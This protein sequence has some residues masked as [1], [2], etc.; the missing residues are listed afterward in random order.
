MRTFLFD[1]PAQTS[2]FPLSPKFDGETID[3]AVD[4]PRLQRQL[5]RVRTRVLEDRGWHSLA[6]LGAQTGIPEASI[7]ARIRDLRKSRFG[8]YTI[9]RRRRSAGTF[10]Y[11][12]ERP[13]HLEDR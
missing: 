13:C 2:L 11:H 10:E 1:A 9:A 12:L 3:V 4:T 7:S 6:E 8:S 5:D